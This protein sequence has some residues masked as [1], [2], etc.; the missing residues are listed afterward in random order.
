MGSWSAH[1]KAD[2]HNQAH[3]LLDDTWV[4]LSVARWHGKLV[5][6]L[7]VVSINCSHRLMHLATLTIW[8][9]KTRHLEV[10]WRKRLSWRQSQTLR[11]PASY[12][13]CLETSSLAENEGCSTSKSSRQL[14]RLIIYYRYWESMKN[15]LYDFGFTKLAHSYPLGTDVCWLCLMSQRDGQ[16]GSFS[17]V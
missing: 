6:T 10:C 1:H 17:Q 12:N 3:F 9:R 11:N 8:I 2:L 16:L 15:S 14:L 4:A 7:D 5:E 13:V